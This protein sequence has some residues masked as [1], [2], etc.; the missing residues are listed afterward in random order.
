MSS[1]GETPII[2]LSQIV[3]MLQ[4][5]LPIVVQVMVLGLTVSLV[6]NLLVPTLKEAFGGFK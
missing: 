3:S 2:D 6:F 4:Q 1:G 5:I